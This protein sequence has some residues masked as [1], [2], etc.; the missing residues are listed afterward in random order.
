MALG[1]QGLGIKERW[2]GGITKKHEETFGGYDCY[3][4]GSDISKV[5]TYVKSFQIVAFICV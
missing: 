3:L 2:E 4:D 1:R 5:Y